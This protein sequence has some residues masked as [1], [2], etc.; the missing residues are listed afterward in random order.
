[1]YL[2]NTLKCESWGPDSQFCMCEYKPT[3][4]SSLC[5]LTDFLPD[6]LWGWCKQHKHTTLSPGR[7]KN[8]NSCTTQRKHMICWF[9]FKQGLQ[10]VYLLVSSFCVFSTR[11]SDKGKEKLKACGNLTP[12]PLCS[13]YASGLRDLVTKR[14]QSNHHL[15]KPV[16]MKN[17]QQLPSLQLHLSDSK[18][19]VFNHYAVLSLMCGCWDGKTALSA[20]QILQCTFPLL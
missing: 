7:K 1:M 20:F 10:Y 5:V 3:K 11:N 14:P 12:T 2:Q 4:G 18:G 8:P 9:I 6:S 17:W 19:F 13:T 16:A 15:W